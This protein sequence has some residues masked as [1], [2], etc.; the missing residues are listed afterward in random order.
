[1]VIWVERGRERDPIVGHDLTRLRGGVAGTV[2]VLYLG[3]M[4]D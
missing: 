2:H 1:M 4:R 3:S